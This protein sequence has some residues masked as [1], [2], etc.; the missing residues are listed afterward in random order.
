MNGTGEAVINVQYI[1]QRRR[2]FLSFTRLD[3]FYFYVGLFR[4]T[5]GANRT[6][7][8]LKECPDFRTWSAKT[9]FLNLVMVCSRGF[10]SGLLDISSRAPQ[11]VNTVLLRRKHRVSEF[12]ENILDI[13]N[14]RVINNLSSLRARIYII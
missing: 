5:L 4:Q 2:V 7:L 8:S 13:I 12:R 11:F 1:S 3:S 9:Y 6:S 10:S 14:Y